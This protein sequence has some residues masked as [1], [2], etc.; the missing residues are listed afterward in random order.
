MS[1]SSAQPELRSPAERLGAMVRTVRRRWPLALAVFALVVVVGAVHVTTATRIYEA[2]AVILLQPSDAVTT[3][4][5]GAPGTPVNAQRD[6]DT[7]AALV[8]ATPV[9]DAVR[10]RLGLTE[11]SDALLSRVHL[12]G[13]QTSNLVTV[14]VRD[15]NAMRAAQIATAF[16]RAAG[17]YRAR[18]ARGQLQ[19][20]IDAGRRSLL[21]MDDSSRRVVEQRLQELSAAEAVQ[22]G[23]MRVVQPA[24]VPASPAAPRAALALG[25]AFGLGLALALGAALLAERLDDRLRDAAEVA[26]CFASPVLAV[27]PCER[28][29]RAAGAAE[30]AATLIDRGL[31]CDG[32]VLLFADAGE[33][34]LAS[35]VTELVCAHLAA[36]GRSA[37]LVETRPREAMQP[38]DLG[39]RRHDGPGTL[40]LQHVSLTD[41]AG[42]AGSPSYAVL[43]IMPGEPEADAP[44]RGRDPGSLIPIARR[45]AD[46]VLVAG[47]VADLRRLRALLGASDAVAL[48]A[49]VRCTK[50][51]AAPRAR[52]AI[53]SAPSKLVGVVLAE[54]G[55]PAVRRRRAS[56]PRRAGLTA[57]VIDLPPHLAE[58][59][60]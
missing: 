1:S 9:A 37:L 28:G 52:A 40:S 29:S 51:S 55:R 59:A 30:L 24:A 43:G 26:A 45:L 27:L 2:H 18:V 35:D 60:R 34:P 39:P 42:P 56:A 38:H 12:D 50:A 19:D 3:T 53:A 10:R 5:A 20:A 57:P 49:D 25:G 58:A 22:T 7:N 17:E 21:D 4:L 48:I 11:S 16:A 41:E 6:L 54:S 8:T 36:A 31:A 33:T 46:V 14:A 23:G 32:Q 47:S 13:Q 44:P 15:A